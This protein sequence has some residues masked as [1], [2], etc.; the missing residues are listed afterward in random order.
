MS[1][2]DLIGSDVQAL[3]GDDDATSQTLLAELLKRK[4]GRCGWQGGLTSVG[5][6]TCMKKAF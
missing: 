1:L 2:H 6:Q 4:E 5:S 3:A